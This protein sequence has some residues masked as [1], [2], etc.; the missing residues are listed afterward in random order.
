MANIPTVSWDETKPD[1]G[2]DLSLGDDDIKEFKKQVREVI[3][4]DH[5]MSSSGQ[6]ANWG[7]HNIVT[8]LVQTTITA[9]ANAGKLYTKDVSG[10]A[11]LHFKDEDDNEIQ[12]TSG[13]KIHLV[14]SS[15]Q[16]DLLYYSA[17]GT[18]AR[19]AKDTNESRY[20]SNQGTNNNPKWEQVDL[21]TG[22]SGQLPMANGGTG[23]NLSDPGADRIAFWDDGASSMAWLAPSTGIQIS[24]TNLALKSY[25]SGWF[26]VSAGNNYT[27]THNLG[28]QAVIWIL[29]FS[30]NSSGANCIVLH[31][32]QQ[33]GS[34][35]RGAVIHD[36]TTT[37]VQIET[38][39][40]KVT[41]GYL[42]TT[43]GNQASG[44]YRIIGI[45]I[46]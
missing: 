36:I 44:Y 20:L 4:A 23:A 13:G 8:L 33:E 12:L 10:K 5:E 9:L 11:E 24:G 25:D 31:D 1:G 35:Q 27:K 17:A 29:L 26:A 43:Y 18:V 7:H 46:A 2:R 28:T 22:V 3:A 40:N 14:A 42:D 45:A 39:T 38:G 32:Q 30:T 21:S 19:L 41:P 37:E 6:G 34:D 16:G 15:A